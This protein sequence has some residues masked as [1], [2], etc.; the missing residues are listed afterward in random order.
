[1]QHHTLDVELFGANSWLQGFYMAALAAASEMADFL[2]DSDADQLR[3][4]LEKGKAYTKEHLFSGEYFIQNIDLKDKSIVEKFDSVKEYWNEESG[5]IKYQIAG[6]SSIDQLTG[7]WH[8]DIL[9]LGDLFDPAQK[10]TAL[11]SMMKYN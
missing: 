10:R 4:L 11:S 7:Q 8:A 2:G 5:E 6:G 3:S 1:M 9:G